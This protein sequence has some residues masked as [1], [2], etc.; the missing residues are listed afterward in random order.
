MSDVGIK[1]YTNGEITIHWEPKKCIHAARCVKALPVVFK[2]K[3]KPWITMEAANTV[4]IKSAI[5]QCPSG[6]LT[7]T[8]NQ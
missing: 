1:Q 6:A 3:S 4:E 2:P 5:D 7:Y 8:I